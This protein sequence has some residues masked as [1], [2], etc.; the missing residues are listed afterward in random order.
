MKAPTEKNL[1][2]YFHV[3]QGMEISVSKKDELGVTSLVQVVLRLQ[4]ILY[5]L[6]KAGRLWSHLL[7]E[8]LSDAGFE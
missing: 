6:K 4:K 3:P 5:E 2:L 8:K 7:H 1:H